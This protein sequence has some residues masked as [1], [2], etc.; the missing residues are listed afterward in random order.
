MV[1]WEVLGLSIQQ[2]IRVTTRNDQGFKTRED[3]TSGGQAEADRPIGNRSGGFGG[4]CRGKRAG[5]PF[6]EQDVRNGGGGKE[7]SRRV[8]K[9]P[10][11]GCF[12]RGTKTHVR[13]VV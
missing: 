12:G 13:G 9:R 3:G 6:G 7:R 11:G 2:R 10:G 4:G 5:C 1:V 8:I